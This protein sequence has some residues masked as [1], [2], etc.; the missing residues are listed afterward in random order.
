MK[1]KITTYHLCLIALAV[2]INLVGGQI[3]LILRLPI[4]LDSIGTILI[5]AACGP[6]Y[7]MIPNV[8]SG[9][10]LG[11]TSDI[12]S[13]YYAPVGILFGFLTGL[14]WQKKKRQALVD[15]C[16]SPDRD[17]SQLTGQLADH[18][19][20][21]WRHHLIRLQRHRAA[22]GQDTAG[23][24]PQLLHQCKYAPITLTASSALGSSMH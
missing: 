18:R 14:A 23:T 20:I 4:Y 19:W 5:A 1:H 12:Y 2:V 22:S 7:G 11:M 3:A 13:L 8:L 6:V 15:L 24:D 21:I 17:H 16:S 10:V 9:L